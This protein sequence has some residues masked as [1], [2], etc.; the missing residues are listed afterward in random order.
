MFLC[1]V[2]VMIMRVPSRKSQLISNWSS[3]TSRLS[4]SVRSAV[5]AVWYLAYTSVRPSCSSST[6]L[7]ARSA[8]LFDSATSMAS[9]LRCYRPVSRVDAIAASKAPQSFRLRNAP[10]ALGDVAVAIRVHLHERRLEARRDEHVLEVRVAPVDDE[11]DDALVALDGRD[12]LLLLER[13][14]P[15]VVNHLENFTSRVQ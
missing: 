10:L 15:V 4:C 7:A 9:S 3:A 2:Y 1:T 12:D 14:A 6:A 8:S 5:S 11:L 13:A